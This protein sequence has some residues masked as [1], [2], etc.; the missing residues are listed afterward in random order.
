MKIF[1][2]QLEKT[3]VWYNFFFC[4]FAAWGT[5]I[6]WH[7]NLSGPKNPNIAHA[8]DKWHFYSP[9]LLHTPDLPRHKHRICGIMTYNHYHAKQCFHC[10][11]LCLSLFTVSITLPYIIASTALCSHMNNWLHM[12]E[13]M[14]FTLI[15]QI[16]WRKSLNSPCKNSPTFL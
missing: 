1:V 8:E 14:C 7:L 3:S 10:L 13:L 4:N 15:Q 11:L 9:E 2:Y 5:E 6:T 16:K 12:R